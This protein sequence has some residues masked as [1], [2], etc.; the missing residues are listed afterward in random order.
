MKFPFTNKIGIVVVAIII[1]V[2]FLNPFVTIETGHVGIKKTFGK[3]GTS[4]LEPGIH[5][6]LPL[7]QTVQKVDVRVQTI[8]YTKTSAREAEGISRRNHIQVLDQRGLPIAIE[9]TVQFRLVKERASETVAR[10]GTDWAEKIVN[11]TVREVVRDIV[12]GY[13]GELIPIKRQKIAI[14]ISEKIKEK[15]TSISNN[16]VTI[17]GV[18]LRNVQLPAE[19]AQKIKEVQVAKQEAEKT[20]YIEEK[21]KR[22]QQ[23]KII[24][25]ETKKLERIKHAEGVAQSRINEAAGTAKANRLIQKSITPDVITWKELDVQMEVAKSLQKNP[26]ATVFLNI[27]TSNNFHMWLDKKQKQQ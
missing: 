25:A 23:V 15:I 21:A 6:I 14:G 19:I 3:F 26:N 9:L 20:V 18:Q 12:G 11:P 1:L 22:E 24:Q 13:P 4:E 2:L 10:W 17:V 27:P 16:S 8:N 7:M 5:L